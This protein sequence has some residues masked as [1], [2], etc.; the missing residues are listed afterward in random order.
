MVRLSS[1]PWSSDELYSSHLLQFFHDFFL[2]YSIHS[3]CLSLSFR[4][5]AHTLKPLHAVLMSDLSRPRFSSAFL[6]RLC[7]IECRHLQ[8]SLSTPNSFR[9]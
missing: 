6:I 2:D 4:L 1:S 9:K 5:A 3:Q 8:Y 7:E